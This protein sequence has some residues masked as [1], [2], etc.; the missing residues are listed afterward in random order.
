MVRNFASSFHCVVLCQGKSLSHKSHVRQFF[1]KLR[2]TWISCDSNRINKAVM[3]TT[4]LL[5]G[6][7][8]ALFCENCFACSYGT[9]LH[10]G[11]TA[12]LRALAYIVCCGNA[13]LR[14]FGKKG[15]KEL[16]R[17]HN[18]HFLVQG[19]NWAYMFLGA[20]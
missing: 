8:P 7:C 3:V 13:A 4:W 18:L 15:A 9:D 11:V 1:T 14:A 17:D 16:I 10:V 20:F 12:A 2:G 5:Q 6:L 19:Y